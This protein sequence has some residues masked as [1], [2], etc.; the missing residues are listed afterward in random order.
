MLGFQKSSLVLPDVSTASQL[1]YCLASAPQMASFLAL[2]SQQK[3]SFKTEQGGTLNDG[4]EDGNASA[5]VLKS[6]FFLHS[7]AFSR[8]PC[9]ALL[10][11]LPTRS[12]NQMVRPNECPMI[13]DEAF[14]MDSVL[15]TV[16]MLILWTG[17]DKHMWTC[18]QLSAVFFP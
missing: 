18:A 13:S 7:S 10:P 17:T 16:M 12:L 6:H 3:A 11:Q 15:T 9:C 8:P 1:M 14:N 5:L 4:L 2:F